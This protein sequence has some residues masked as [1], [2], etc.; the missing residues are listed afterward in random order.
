MVM[1]MRREA[2]NEV[3]LKRP[4]NPTDRYRTEDEWKIV[5]TAEAMG[6]SKAPTSKTKIPAVGSGRGKCVHLL[7]LRP[8][9]SGGV[10]TVTESERGVV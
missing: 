4:S 9:F 2:L 10:A 3:G 5:L 8:A 1:L 7:P 6:T